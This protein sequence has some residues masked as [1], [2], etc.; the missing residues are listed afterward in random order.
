MNDEMQKKPDYG[1]ISKILVETLKL[2]QSPVAVKLAKSPEG[3]P[4]GVEEI[5]DTVRHCQMVAMAG[6]EGKIFYARADKHACAG[7]AWAL[8]LKEIT[9]S[10]QTGEFYFKL[11]KFES[12]ASCMRTI[13]SIP[14]VH[15]TSSTEPA[16]YAT[17]YA[18]LEK[19][20]FDPHVIIIVSQ[21]VMMLKFAQA[22]LYKMGGRI[23][24]E[25]SGIQSVCAD[26]CTQPYLT[27]KANISLGCDGS[28]KFSGI[29]DD[30][31][32]MGIPAEIIE[33]VAEAVPIVSGAP[34]SKTR[35]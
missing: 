19:T 4:E 6:R 8:G 2:P 12:W 9:P 32:V 17:V 33:E 11:G 20:P 16:T 30:Y 27:G 24:S 13:K 7:G 5:K 23:H 1:K 28:R 35:K 10:L 22:L 31:M 34:G 18:P 15:K 25:F 14:N 3:I 29:D 26:A 21:P